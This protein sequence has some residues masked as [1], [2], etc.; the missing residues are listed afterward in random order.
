MRALTPLTSA[1]LVLCVLTAC[2]GTGTSDGRGATAQS[3]A[4]TGR[5]ATP[6]STPGSASTPSAPPIAPSEGF[7]TSNITLRDGDKRIEVTAWVADTP[8]LRRRGLMERTSLPADAGM[9]FVFDGPTRGGFWMKNTRIPLSI[10]FFDDDRRLLETLDMPP[11]EEDPCPLY[12]PGAEYRYALEVNQG[13][14][15]E[16]GIAADWVIDIGEGLDAS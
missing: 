8:N 1:L 4:T 16:R 2:T 11:C 12:A 10:A 15:A 14:Y 5:T 7:A 6:Q 13:F 9:V 3:T